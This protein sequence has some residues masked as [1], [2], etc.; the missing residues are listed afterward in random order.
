MNRPE[1][2][3]LRGVELTG[4]NTP[5]P[6]PLFSVFLL[7]VK[8]SGSW[9]YMN[10]ISGGQSGGVTPGSMPN[11]AVKP[12]S[13]DGT[14]EAIRGR[15]GRCRKSFFY[16][17]RTETD[18]REAESSRPRPEILRFFRVSGLGMTKPSLSSR[19]SRLCL[20]SRTSGATEGSRVCPCLSS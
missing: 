18:Y 17:F 10:W 13:A 4:T 14:A 11:P 19:T 8:E 3:A 15:V 12:S 20:S 16:V 9:G 2:Y 6:F 5:R 1:V 7:F